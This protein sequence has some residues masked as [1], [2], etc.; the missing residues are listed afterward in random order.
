MNHLPTGKIYIGALKDD[1]RWNDYCTSSNKVSK[2]MKDAPHEWEKHILLKNFNHTIKWSEV[3]ALE[4]SIIEATALAIGWNRMFNGGVYKGQIKLAEQASSPN[5]GKKGQ[6]PWNKGKKTG[7]NAKRSEK[8]KGRPAW[9]KGLKMTEEQ[10]KNMGGW[11][12]LTEEQALARKGR[13]SPNKGKK[14]GPEAALKAWETKKNKA[15][16]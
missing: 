6:I 15:G 5:K 11:R 8:I 12:G 7:H 9:N 14:L 10:K 3:I 16:R 2:M 1:R 4:Q 13:P